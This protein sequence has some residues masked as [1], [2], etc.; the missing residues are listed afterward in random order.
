[1]RRVGSPTEAGVRALF[2]GVLGLG[3][4]VILVAAGLGLSGGVAR[5]AAARAVAEHAGLAARD[6][7]ARRTL[8]AVGPARPEAVPSPQGSEG[9]LDAFQGALAGACV[10]H[11]VRLVSFEAGGEPVAASSRYAPPPAAG[12]STPESE[13]KAVETKVQLRGRIADIYSVIADLKPCPAP[14]EIVSL[15]LESDGGGGVRASLGATVSI[16][17]VNPAGEGTVASR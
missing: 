11:G 16:A 1:M 3:G 13:R 9:A 10:A 4:G 2:R 14:F 15:A 7:A 5:G 8:A 6:E 12:S 17:T